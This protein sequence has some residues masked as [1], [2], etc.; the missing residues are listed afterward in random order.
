MT[1]DYAEPFNIGSPEEL[2]VAEF[3]SKIAEA[4]GVEL[5]VENKPL[6]EDDPKVRRPDISKAKELLNWEA[7]V[8]LREGLEKTI[9]YFK[10]QLEIS[11]HLMD[12][13]G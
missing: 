6:P 3:A 11:D 1:S 10:D 4:V 8:S 12:S 9:P 5:H 7:Q 13:P 2:S